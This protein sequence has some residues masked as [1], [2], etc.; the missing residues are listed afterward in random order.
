MFYAMEGDSVDYVLS[1]Q[2]ELWQKYQ[3]PF[4]NGRMSS[5]YHVVTSM[6]RLVNKYERIVI[7]SNQS[8]KIDWEAGGF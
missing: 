7:L 5:G 8:A 2:I 6:N 4:R 3:N 1:N